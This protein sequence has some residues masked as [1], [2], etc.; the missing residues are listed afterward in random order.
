MLVQYLPLWN[1]TDW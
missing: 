1:K